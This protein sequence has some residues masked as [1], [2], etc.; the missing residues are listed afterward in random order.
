[1]KEIFST[2]VTRL[3]N[4]TYGCRLFKEGE[5]VCEV[6]TKNRMEIQPAIKDMLRTFD[7]MGYASNMAHASR[8]RNNNMPVNSNKFIWH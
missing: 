4:G 8:M 5:L 1:M 3:G 6:R 7:K 2:K